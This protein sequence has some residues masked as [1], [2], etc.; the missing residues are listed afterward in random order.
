MR[1]FPKIRGTCLGVP[2]RRMLVLGGLYQGSPTY[3]NYHRGTVDMKGCWFRLT[4]DGH[5]LTSTNRATMRF[6]QNPPGKTLNP[7]P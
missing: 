4:M 3:G 5:K 1:K 7:E 2:V 6:Q